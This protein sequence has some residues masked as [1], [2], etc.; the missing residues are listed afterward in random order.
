MI[1]YSQED[2]IAFHMGD[3]ADETAIRA[4]LGQCAVCDGLSDSIAETL[5]VFSADRVPSADFEANWQRVR[6]CM[7]VHAGKDRRSWWTRFAWPAVGSVCAAAVLAGFAM[8]HYNVGDRRANF[9]FNR[10]GPLTMEPVDERDHL[11]A[12]ER[13][14]TEVNHS[15]GELD[16]ATLTSARSLGLSNA[17]YVQKAQQRG[18]MV[19]AA[20]L[21]NLGHVLTDIQHQPKKDAGTWRLRLEMNTHGLLLDIRILQQSDR[22]DEQN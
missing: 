19:E 1:H 14:L 15:H 5:R 17:M 4:H 12:A 8:H 7:R 11:D 6:G 22:D 13:F 2:L 3:A 21:E 9:A 18:D 20:T 10:P 16:E